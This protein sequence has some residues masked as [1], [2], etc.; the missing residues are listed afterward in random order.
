MKSERAAGWVV[1]VEPF[2]GAGVE[3]AYGFDD[4]ADFDNGVEHEE[5]EGD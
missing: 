3:E 2:A 4:Q 5:W 1:D